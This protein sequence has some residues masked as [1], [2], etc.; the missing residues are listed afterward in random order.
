MRIGDGQQAILFIGAQL[1]K[2]FFAVRQHAGKL[3]HL[4]ELMDMP[5]GLG[6]TRA[7]DGFCERK[8]GHESELSGKKVMLARSVIYLATVGKPVAASRAALMLVGEFASALPDCK[9]GKALLGMPLPVIGIG[10][11]KN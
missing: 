6:F 7:S 11:G 4:G 1:Q 5:E 9:K 3:G 8:V 10:A 2:W